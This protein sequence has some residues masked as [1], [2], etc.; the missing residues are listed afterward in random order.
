MGDN[1][2]PV[3]V[4]DT[5]ERRYRT[6]SYW[7]ESLNGYKGLAA[8]FAAVVGVILILT[9]PSLKEIAAKQ[10]FFALCAVVIFAIIVF[11]FEPLTLIFLFGFSVA[12]LGAPTYGVCLLF[13]VKP[14]EL[15]I[16]IS[17][18]LGVICGA[19]MIYHYFDAKRN[20]EWASEI[21]HS[22]GQW[23]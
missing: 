1:R 16:I 18:L 10:L 12:L 19:F 15:R 5:V 7:K 20:T 22:P 9:L 8:V 21:D 4:Q 13:G 3:Y 14:I 23:R 17:S 2:S 11:F 6:Y